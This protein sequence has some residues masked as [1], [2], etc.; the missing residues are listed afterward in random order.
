V[1]NTQA[2]ILGIV[3]GLT[4]YLPV[5][6]S[7]HLVIVPHLLGWHFAD[8]E[9]FIF[10]V[11]VQMGTLVGV[12]LYFFSPLKQVILAALKGIFMGKPFYNEDARLGWMVLLASLPA[13]FLGLAFKDIISAYFSSSKDAYIFLIFTG[14][15]LIVA[16]YLIRSHEK[17]F[18]N[19]KDAI[20]IGFF[21]ALALLP[22]ISR[23][24][25][26]I[27]AGMFC[28]LERKSAAQF[29]FLMSIPVMLG[30]GIIASDDLFSNQ[31]LLKQMTFPL[32]TGFFTAA[33]TGFFVIRWFM[34]YISA[35]KLY[36]FALYCIF[37][38]GMG[39]FVFA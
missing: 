10:D 15:L 7:A 34:A 36:Y 27:A 38:G 4:E 19:K 17:V 9:A 26:T 33:V 29:S 2:A 35:Q 1:T 3:Q 25:S 22:G 23:S 18:P 32:L 8:D 20:I 39:A 37:L 5:S 16:E 24:G 12:F 21:Q 31:V 28:G 30:A 14:F 11:L 6:S 13:G